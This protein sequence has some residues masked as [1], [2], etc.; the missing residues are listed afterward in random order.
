[1]HGPQE[2]NHWQWMILKRKIPLCPTMITQDAAT[3]GKTSSKTVT[4][5]MVIH[6]SQMLPTI[7]VLRIFEHSYFSQ[8]SA[9]ESM[10]IAFVQLAYAPIYS[11]M[12]SGRSQHKKYSLASQEYNHSVK[13]L[14][15]DNRL[16]ENASSH[17]DVAAP[18]F[19]A[20]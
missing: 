3:Q 13:K 20:R 12:P 19:I 4:I 5:E 15:T 17:M 18:Q 11:L 1:M 6:C 7:S 8:M 9:I 10:K 2:L 14:L 16:G